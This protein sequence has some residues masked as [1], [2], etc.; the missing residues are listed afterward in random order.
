MTEQYPKASARERAAY[1]VDVS[2]VPPVSLGPGIDTHIVCG[3]DL[4]LSFA[5]IEPGA[6]GKMHSH[7]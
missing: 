1:V 5:T 6:I 2:S 4:T 3:K 7:P